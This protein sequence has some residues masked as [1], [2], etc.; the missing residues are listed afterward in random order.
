MGEGTPVKFVL[1][2]F[3]RPLRPQRNLTAVGSLNLS[4]K[5]GVSQE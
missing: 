5:T 4:I 1:N 2:R 3:F